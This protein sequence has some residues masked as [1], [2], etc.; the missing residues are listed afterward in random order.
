MNPF[1][2]ILLSTAFISLL[3]ACGGGGDDGGN[4]E[5][6]ATSSNGNTQKYT[7]AEVQSVAATTALSVSAG[8]RGGVGT[9]LLG[10]FFAQQTSRLAGTEASTVKSCGDLFSLSAGTYT[11]T[12]TKS[13][14][15]RGFDIGDK[16]TVTFNN[17]KFNG[18]EPIV[19]G[20]AI[21]VAT[22][23]VADLAVS[24]Y[25]YPYDLMLTGLTV[26]YRGI[27]LRW[28][29]AANMESKF[30][31]S[32]NTV[33]VT[34]KLTVPLGQKLQLMVDGQTLE[35][36]GGATFLFTEN[37]QVGK[38]TLSAQL[39]GSVK[40]T[41]SGQTTP[42]EVNTVTPL[43]GSTD[44]QANF[45]ATAGTFNAKDTTRNLPVRAT[46]NSTAASIDGDTDGNGSLDLN[47]TS[48]WATL[49]TP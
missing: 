35:Y 14:V 43:F 5:V 49:T 45:S 19:N 13:T 7:Q 33:L 34:Q 20:T 9:A 23:S 22:K 36:G 3:A 41:R 26:S 8:Y 17:C 29:G 16:F 47:V 2:K 11:F 32:T 15:R 39:N 24:D 38:A 28:D 27:N 12:T 6:P 42:L 30:K 31:A 46:F 25:E 48:S 40:F 1:I 44:G 18:S 10:S 21:F 4:G 37:S